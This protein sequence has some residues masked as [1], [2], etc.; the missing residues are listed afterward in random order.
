MAQLN[1]GEEKVEIFKPLEKY[2]DEGKEQFMFM[3]IVKQN[4][5]EIYLYKNSNTRRYLNIDTEGN[6]YWYNS[7]NSSYYLVDSYQA[8]KYANS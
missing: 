4:E 7:R 3:G 1:F 5:K 2:V 6:F 8:I